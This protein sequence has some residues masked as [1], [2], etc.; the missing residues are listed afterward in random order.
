MKSI[1]KVCV[2]GA[3]TMGSG[4]AQV[5]ALAGY[6]TILLDVNTQVLAKGKM[7]IENG[8][9]FLVD[10][11]KITKEKRIAVLDKLGYTSDI[12]DCV[13]DVVIEAIVE[14]LDAKT[15]LFNQLA[16][17]N[18]E[19]TIFASNT[20]SLSITDLQKGISYPHRLLGMHFF[21][22]APIMK[23]VEIVHGE[24]TADDI[25]QVMVELTKKLG[26]TPVI[27]K[28]SPGFIVNRMARPYYLEAMKLIEMSIASFETVDR[29]LEASGFKMGPFK[30]MDLIGMDINFSVSNIVWHAL[31]EPE[32]LR[33]SDLQKQKVEANKLG[34]K[35][36]EGFY[37]YP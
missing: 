20:S 27:C 16:Q 1:E 10:K 22:P 33:P 24:Q 34:K 8:L 35:T 36:G 26:K 18:D 2:C 23:L 7:A 3:G 14:K 12:Q 17:V 5:I 11:Q 6:K 13:A 29:V 9:Q 31:E 19:Q 30:L 28:D 15:S 25:I 4:I 32:R 21:N 37:T